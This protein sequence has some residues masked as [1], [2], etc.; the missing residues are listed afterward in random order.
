[1]MAPPPSEK[2]KPSPEE[3]AASE[4]STDWPLAPFVVRVPKLTPVIV[5]VIGS[6]VAWAGPAPS[7]S[8]T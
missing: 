4:M 6:A 2:M 8:G 5:K 3:L 7:G 1:M